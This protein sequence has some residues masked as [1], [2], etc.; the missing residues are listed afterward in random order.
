[1]SY[2]EYPINS[3][4]LRISSDLFIMLLSFSDKYCHNLFD[5]SLNCKMLCK[6]LISWPLSST[7]IS[8]FL[9]G[10]NSNWY[11]VNDVVL[12]ILFLIVKMLNPFISLLAVW[13]I[14]KHSTLTF[15]V[16]SISYKNVL[17]CSVSLYMSILYKY[18]M[19][20]CSS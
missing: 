17:K 16:F 5:L 20:P 18:S 8:T 4:W 13:S 6:F 1:M 19:L 3:I 15:E 14:Y 9:L 2:N 7:S 11:L 12:L 10:S